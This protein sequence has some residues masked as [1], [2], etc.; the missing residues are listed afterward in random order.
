MSMN[1]RDV[2]NFLKGF[3]V[4]ATSPKKK[5]KSKE[6]IT[7]DYIEGKITKEQ[8]IKDMKYYGY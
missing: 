2:Y 1:D 7:K 3:A 5:I 8:Y 4:K 6:Q